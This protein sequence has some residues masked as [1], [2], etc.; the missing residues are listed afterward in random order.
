MSNA[1]RLGR[2]CLPAICLLAGAANDSVVGDERISPQTVNERFLAHRL[3]MESIHFTAT[4]S[5]QTILGGDVTESVDR[6]EA[7]SDFI[8]NRSRYDVLLSVADVQ[9]FSHLSEPLHR[10]IWVSVPRS[11]WFWRP[12]N[13][14]TKSASPSFP[15]ADWHVVK[16]VDIRSVGLIGANDLMD[17]RYEF[18]ILSARWLL[19]ERFK[20]EGTSVSESSTTF[21]FIDQKNDVNRDVTVDS[22]LGWVPIA[23]FI[24]FV[25]A[26]GVKT[27]LV[28][29]TVSWTPIDGISIPLEWVTESFS[30]GSAPPRSRVT[31]I[32]FSVESLNE[33]ISSAIFDTEAISF[34]DGT[35]I[36]NTT[37]GVPVVESIVASDKSSPSAM[38]A[39]FSPQYSKVARLNGSRQMWL[40]VS[41]LLVAISLA[42]WWCMRRLR[43]R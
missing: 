3:A 37:S 21:H 19:D 30:P 36:M 12:P 9:K 6:I 23:E 5:T 17:D 25:D 39:E 11:E 35:V 16:P 38:R 15:P 34:P 28:Q 22:S 31:H 43:A 14:L 7:W 24:Y 42:G 29:S 40:I 41:N 8:G 33:E 26:N 1:R 10:R 4:I 2:L 13:S 27:P 20:F 32:T 18:M